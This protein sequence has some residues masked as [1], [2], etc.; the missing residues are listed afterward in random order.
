[1]EQVKEY[2]LATDIPPHPTP[3]SHDRHKRMKTR[4]GQVLDGSNRGFSTV[5][6]SADRAQANQGVSMT[7]SYQKT[8]ESTAKNCQQAKC[9]PL[10]PIQ[11]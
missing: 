4:T 8:L 2:F 5:R 9:D 7:H 3:G 6:M 10:P 11:C 1:M